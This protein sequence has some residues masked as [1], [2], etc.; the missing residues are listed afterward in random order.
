MPPSQYAA[1]LRL[2]DPLAL[3]KTVVTGAT[4]HGAG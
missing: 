2:S 1:H 3:R 4:Q